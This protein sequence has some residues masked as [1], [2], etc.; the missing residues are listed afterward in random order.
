LVIG[1]L[2][3]AT[4]T[5]AVAGLALA[6]GVI[7]GT[8]VAVVPTILG[9]IVVVVVL[10]RR[11]PHAASFEAVQHDL[12]VIFASVVVALDLVVI[13][14]WLALGGWTAQLLVALA[15]LLI[16]DV[17]VAAMLHPARRSV[18]RAWVEG[19]RRRR[20]AAA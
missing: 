8:I 7:Y 18:A 6:A 19:E 15:V 12:S 16:V 5:A 9:G 13:V 17:A 2:V 10:T 20:S 14:Y 4:S 11:H 1:I 3:A